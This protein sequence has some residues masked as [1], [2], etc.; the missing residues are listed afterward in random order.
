ME[1]PVKVKVIGVERGKGTVIYFKNG[2]QITCHNVNESSN[3]LLVTK[4]DILQLQKSMDDTL[5]QQNEALKAEL[6]NLKECIS[7]L[8][9]IKATFEKHKEDT[10]EKM[11]S[12][13][14]R[15]LLN[16]EEIGRLHKSCSQTEEK[17]KKL[18]LFVK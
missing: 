8:K 16:E 7:P 6:S 5:L 12:I 2:V 3:N 10:Q 1:N 14:A 4:A 9:Y 13:F 15:V 11:T 18:N 17:Y